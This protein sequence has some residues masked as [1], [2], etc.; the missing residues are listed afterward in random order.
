MDWTSFQE[1]ITRSL[2]YTEPAHDVDEF[3]DPLDSVTRDI[4]DR[5]CPLK[6]S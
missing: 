6:L 1:D 5:H 2:F 3:G 4:L